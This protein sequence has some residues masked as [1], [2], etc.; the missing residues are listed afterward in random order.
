[1]SNH[2]GIDEAESAAACPPPKTDCAWR[3]S[4]SQAFAHCATSTDSFMI[5]SNLGSRAK[6]HQ[7]MHM[8]AVRLHPGD[9]C[10]CARGKRNG[11]MAAAHCPEPASV[12]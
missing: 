10:P 8:I 6:T 2:G 9:L 11:R 4:A 5:D 7:K 3:A 12:I 1:L